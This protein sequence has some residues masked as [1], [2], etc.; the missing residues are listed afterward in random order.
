MNTNGEKLTWEAIVKNDPLEGD[1]WKK[2]PEDLDDD[3]SDDD[4]YEFDEE[5][6]ADRQVKMAFCDDFFD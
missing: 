3:I 4:G 5:V 2:W 1:H 6:T